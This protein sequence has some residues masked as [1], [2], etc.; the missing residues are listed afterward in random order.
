DPPP[1]PRTDTTR[2]A[3]QPARQLA[4]HP[5]GKQG[6]T[7]AATAQQRL[8]RARQYWQELSPVQQQQVEARLLEHGKQLQVAVFRRQPESSALRDEL[9]YSL[10]ADYLD[11]IAHPVTLAALPESECSRPENAE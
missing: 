4:S 9:R 7:A 5:A 1:A 6:S 11:R 2:N 8:E 10:L 3:P